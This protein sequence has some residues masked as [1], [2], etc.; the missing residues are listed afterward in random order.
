MCHCQFWPGCQQPLMGF[1][2]RPPPPL[3]RFTTRSPSCL[4]C[5]TTAYNAFFW[6]RVGREERETPPIS[7]TKQCDLKF[8]SGILLFGTLPTSWIWPIT[9]L[10]AIIVVPTKI[11]VNS[12][13]F[14]QDCSCA[15]LYLTTPHSVPSL[16]T[17]QIVFLA[18]AIGTPVTCVDGCSGSPTSHRTEDVSELYP[19]TQEHP[20]VTT[21]YYWKVSNTTSEKETTEVRHSH[22]KNTIFIASLLLTQHVKMLF[23]AKK[24]SFAA[25]I[26][27]RKNKK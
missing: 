20:T 19:P 17:L 18:G 24:V 23:H 6:N 12:T 5:L 15:F 26:T 10:N 16:A 9:L 25:F 22:T 11:T 3:T 8:T 2:H 4:T 7:W 21:K 14:R 1:L 27:V 13:V